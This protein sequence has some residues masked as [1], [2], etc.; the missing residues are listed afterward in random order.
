MTILVPIFWAFDAVDAL[1]LRRHIWPA[2]ENERGDRGLGL[3]FSNMGLFLFKPLEMPRH[4]PCFCLLAAAV[5]GELVVHH[6]WDEN[7]RSDHL[8][9]SMS[10]STLR[11]INRLTPSF[12]PIPSAASLLLHEGPC[13]RRI[14]QQG[15]PEAFMLLASSLL[16]SDILR[17]RHMVLNHRQWDT[18]QK[19]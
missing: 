8:Y 16:N 10:S 2:R 9:G 7:I 19:P 11:S 12:L 13:V 1:L 3:G 17:S 18:A 14:G 15:E 5:C 6:C 4:Y